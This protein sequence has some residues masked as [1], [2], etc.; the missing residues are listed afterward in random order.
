M[1]QVTQ[2]LD[3]MVKIEKLKGVLRKSRPVGFERYEN[4]AEH[5]WHVC[6][7][8][9][10][11][12]DFADQPINIDRVIKMLLLHDLGEIDA[13]DKIVYAAD[14]QEQKSKEWQCVQRL[15]AM[16]PEHQRQDFLVLWEE[17]ENGDT[18]DAKFA[19]AIDRIPPLLHNINDNGHGWKKH[20]ISKEQVLELNSQRIT[21]GGGKIWA[22]VE[23]KLEQA[24]AEGILN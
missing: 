11:L 12:K 3:F 2:I 16:L 24:I 4:S 17:F 8:A 1:N 5:S 7:S 21:A 23:A 14:N 15:F 22:A 10:M 18:P 20:N 19:K 13:G 6:I 9:L